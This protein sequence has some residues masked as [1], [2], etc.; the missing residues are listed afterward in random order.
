MQISR[1]VGC[2]GKWVATQSKFLH[3]KK[4]VLFSYLLFLSFHFVAFPVS[5]L[6]LS[7]FLLFFFFF[8]D[9]ASSIA[10]AA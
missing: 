9:F 1:T 6:P 10:E 2:F 7:P 5:L 4:C 3:L 8:C